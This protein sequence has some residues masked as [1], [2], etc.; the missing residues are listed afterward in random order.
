[1]KSFL[2]AKSS[3]SIE[4]PN[5]SPAKLLENYNFMLE[6]SHELANYESSVKA[7]KLLLTQ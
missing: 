3:D 1:M 6:Q 7:A 5:N 2:I 4:V